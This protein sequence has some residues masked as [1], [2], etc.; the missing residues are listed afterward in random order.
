MD[1]FS[2]QD[3][4]QFPSASFPLTPGITDDNFGLNQ[5]LN[6]GDK[7]PGT[8]GFYTPLS[9][10]FLEPAALTPFDR[11]PSELL[12]PPANLL[13]SNRLAG[14][15]QNPIS[16]FESGFF[17][18]G[19]TGQV[20][21]DFLSDG[22][23]YKGELAFFNLEG[24]ESLGLGSPAFIKEA[25][26]RSLSGN[27]E[28][29]EGDIVI[30][31]ATEG[32]KEDFRFENFNTN[33]GEYLGIK[34][35]QAKPGDKY[36]FMLVPNGK[37]QEVFDALSNNLEL[38]GAKRPLFSM[39]TANPNDAFHVGQI[40]DITG[41][42][43]LF[44][45]EDQRTDTNSDRDYNDVIFRVTGAAGTAA[46][47]SEVIN[48]NL[49]WTKT[50]EG[51]GFLAAVQAPEIE[52]TLA[53]DTGTDNADSLTSD[54]TV[55]GT[56]QTT[57]EIASL[58]AGFNDTPVGDFREVK[59]LLQ[60]DGSF[61][62]DRAKLEEIYGAPLADGAYSLYLQSVDDKGNISS[63]V[64]LSFELDTVSP[65]ITSAIAEDTGVSNTDGIT[66]KLA[67]AG[68]VTG[69]NTFFG[70]SLD[71][72]NF[73]ESA[74]EDD[75]SFALERSQIDI[76]T[77]EVLPDGEGSIYL[78]SSDE[79]GNESAISE[80]SFTLDSALPELTFSEDL[81]NAVFTPGAR[82]AGTANGTG[83]DL[84]FLSYAF[85]E[86]SEISIDVSD[87][88]EFDKELDLSA[89]PAGEHTLSFKAIDR[90]GNE[91][92]VSY[93]VTV[94][95]A[96]DEIAPEIDV[97][98]EDTGVEG[99]GITSRVR[100]EGQITDTSELA[101]IRVGFE[102][103]PEDDVDNPPEDNVDNPPE[104]DVDN[105]PEEGEDNLTDITEEV[106]HD[107]R[108]VLDATKLQEI[109][110]EPLA[111]GEHVL[112]VEATDVHDNTS[113][114]E[115][116]FVLD[117]AEPV[118]N[119]AQSLENATL[120]P[121][122]RISGSAK[123]EEGSGIVEL[124]YRIGD[125][126]EVSVQASETG[127]FDV[128][129]DLSEV[130]N[131]QQTLTVSATDKAGN[132]STQVFPV[133][134]APLLPPTVDHPPEIQVSLVND[135][136]ESD[137]DKIT[138]DPSV[139]GRVTDSGQVAWLR[140]GLEDM[141]EA[142]F[143]DVA[144][145]ADGSWSLDRAQL[146]AIYGDTLPTGDRT[147][148]FQAADTNE[149]VSEIKE[150]T[151]TLEPRPLEIVEISP[152]LT[153]EHVSL[154]REILIRFSAPVNPDTVSSDNLKVIA[155]GAE[156]AGRWVV[157]S[158]G[159]F[160]RF[161]PD[162]TWAESAEIRIEIDGDA[163]TGIDGGILDADAD[164]TPGGD[165]THEFRT[166][167][168]TRIPDT[169]V[170]GYVRDSYSDSPIVG[171]TI[172]VDGLP[173][174]SATTDENGFF[175]LED[176]PGPEFFVHIDG[177]TATNAPEGRSYPIVGKPFH[178]VPGE[179]VQLTMDGTAFD[180]HLPSM[181]EGDVVDLSATESQSVGFGAAGKAALQQMLPNVDAAAWER[182][183][184]E[185]AP[186]SAVDKHG[187]AATK[188][189]I[190]P[191]PPDK[192]PGPLPH[193]I[194]PQ[195]VVSIQALNENGL[196]NN[197]D[198]PAAVTFPNV[199]GLA[200]G[201]Q[202]EIMSFNHDSGRWESVGTGTVTDDGQAI[203][204]DPGVGIL[205]PGWHALVPV[206]IGDSCNPDLYDADRDP[207]RP[208]TYTVVQP[209]PEISGVKDYLFSEDSGS[210]TL[211]FSN[212]AHRINHNLDRC[213][214]EN[215]NATPL[216]VLIDMDAPEETKDFLELPSL[217]QDTRGKAAFE[218]LPEQKTDIKIDIKDLLGDTY[219]EDILYGTRFTIQLGTRNRN[220]I[221][222][223]IDAN[224][225]I[226][227]Y[228]SAYKEE[229]FVYRLLDAADSLHGDGTIEMA[230]TANDSFGGVKR[231]RSLEL[232]VAP[233]AM[234]S[235]EVDDLTHFKYE[236]EEALD[237]ASDPD[238]VPD[239]GIFTFDP[240]A[241]G[242][243]LSSIVRI[244]NPDGDEVGNLTLKGDGELQEWYIDENAFLDALERLSTGALLGASP[245]ELEL[246][247]TADKRQS[248]FDNVV[249][250]VE[251][252]LS[253]FIAGWT[254]TSSPTSTGINID[255]FSTTE[256]RPD[257][258]GNVVEAGSSIV[259]NAFLVDNRVNEVD[260][261]KELVA[262]RASYSV[263]EQNFRLS[264][265]LNEQASGEI[266]IYLDNIFGSPGFHWDSLEPVPEHFQ[267]AMAKIVA[268]E[269]GHNIG[270]E[271]TAGRRSDG[272]VGKVNL[273]NQLIDVM[274]SGYD[275]TYYDRYEF[276]RTADA[277]QVGL[278]TDWTSAQAQDAL[279]Y[280]AAYS[281]ESD[282][283]SEPRL[284]DTIGP[285]PD[286]YVTDVE[287][288]NDGVLYVVADS[289]KAF[290]PNLDF[291]KIP[292]DGSDGEKA[293]E[294]LLL[295][296]VGDRDLNIADFRL[297]GSAGIQFSQPAKTSLAPGETTPLVITFDPTASG[298]QE[299]TLT[300]DNDGSV[301]LYEFQIKGVGQS[302]DGDIRVNADNNNVGGLSVAA[303][304][305]TVAEFATISNSG[306]KAL[307]VS[308][309][310]INDPSGK[311][312]FSVARL[313]NPLVLNPGDTYDLDVTFDAKFV[314]LQ[315]AEISIFSD[316]PDTP[317][318][319]QT[320]VG[321]GLAA[322]GS[323]LQ[324][325]KDYV[326]IDLE[327]G[328]PLRT[329]SLDSGEFEFFLRPNSRYNQAIFDPDSGLISHNFGTT[330]RSG[331][332]TD[333]GTSG[334]EASLA[335][336]SDGDGLPDDVEWAIG[337]SKSAKDTDKDGIDDFVEIQQNLDGLGAGFP[338]GI[339]SSLNLE[340]V[341]EQVVPEGEHI[342]VAT[343]RHGLAIL[344]SN[345]FNNPIQLGQIDLRGYAYDVGVDSN[346]EIAAVATNTGL[347]L[348]D[349]SDPN[350]PQLKQTVP[351]A[352]REVEVANGLAYAANGQSLK[353]VN[354]E[355][356]SVIQN[357]TLPGSGSITGMARE[358]TDL[359]AYVSG[360]RPNN[361]VS[362]IDISSAATGGATV[363]GSVSGLNSTT[364]HRIFAS[365]DTVWVPGGGIHTV[366]VSDPTN[367]KYV[368]RSD[369]ALAARSIALNGPQQN[370]GVLAPDR[371]AFIE[372]YDT[373]DPN[374]TNSDDLLQRFPLSSNPY[375]VAISRGVAYVGTL[376]GVEVL[377]YSP[378]DTEAK[379]PTPVTIASPLTGTELVPGA[380]L[381]VSI[382]AEDDFQLS[383][384]EL[385]ANG[386]AIGQDVSYPF[387]FIT[388]VPEFTPQDTA[389]NLQV[390]AFDTAGNSSLSNTLIWNI[391]DPTDDEP[392]TASI[393]SNVTGNLVEVGER[394]QIDA[395]VRDNVWVS[396]VELL[397]NGKVVD[398]DV[399]A[400]FEFLTVAPEIAPGAETLE[401]QV[402]ATDTGGNTTLSNALSWNLFVPDLEPPTVSINHNAADREPFTPGV[403]VTPGTE[404]PISINASD[405]VEV[406][407]VELLVDG[408]VVDTQESDL[409]DFTV[410]APDAD[411]TVLKIQGRGTDTNG[412]T[413]LSEELSFDINRPSF[414]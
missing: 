54:P 401:V 336:D 256:A 340:G 272:S 317:I 327:S 375:D 304:P 301:P 334:F 348:V 359:Y 26:R 16:P 174:A 195:L 213:E 243:D 81:E 382:D 146:E 214:G 368:R 185:F 105:P 69:E 329:R 83:S 23:S 205:A 91:K 411:G 219:E 298:E 305:L 107:G 145:E 149:N 312:Q 267:K 163:V 309:I 377:N 245:A 137:S 236:D 136:G 55:V 188:A 180:I 129:L 251:G 198:T 318:F 345:E 51:L 407:N 263:A 84:L 233:N 206:T 48:P 226:V 187:N 342:Y 164:G 391:L 239:W 130:A 59:D 302:P 70:L 102:T 246:I 64:E 103:A 351:G 292:A 5:G 65:G 400:P 87:I 34:T 247:D 25:A 114:V 371:R 138:S 384:V 62:F 300:I 39:A 207:P 288:L 79:A 341:S 367:P 88:G 92:V 260:G 276:Y 237:P 1:I 43:T 398:N 42:G 291:G 122:A 89:V 280:F 11:L 7:L 40:A 31:D 100:L 30:R 369:S 147:L 218:L 290:V 399:S 175:I 321:T 109:A 165:I 365:D 397:V 402:R 274:R 212:R 307:T 133:Q 352:A 35:F 166:T 194:T 366:D 335:P 203:A 231:E 20:T 144:I 9:G 116:P 152:V 171:A 378:F 211:S 200:P 45:M 228:S 241:T 273:P 177:S 101:K 376:N 111:D 189:A 162:N 404:I 98:L 13:P 53:S 254:R 326:A 281:V 201:E 244:K 323:A 73:F 199:E 381:A 60:D 230:D 142:D 331:Q 282:G 390:R 173:E 41:D 410:K 215:A 159:E 232:K 10:D 295:M 78:K 71:G 268:H 250:N 238:Y 313:A 86:A 296:N 57:G 322:E 266:D 234:P 393:S 306:D 223:P 186:N 176:M 227:T 364:V 347:E 303:A 157:N 357:L 132:V 409:L 140:V 44:V 134:V 67:I 22:G 386:R 320:V 249:A 285:L 269:L 66:S 50:P 216:M 153:E 110:G 333:L 343:G 106:W 387:D 33:Q 181:A 265:A 271:H 74:L 361:T 358:G 93:P 413:A 184:V 311:D 412:N 63:F 118:V 96:L 204:S 119:L 8:G 90:A 394:I 190:I 252:L 299:A 191:V 222:Q 131:G 314:G 143:V 388:T 82:L 264:E 319:S 2:H 346:L 121:G 193:G 115:I 356:G 209:I 253:S 284:F 18:A 208:S 154:D 21:F 167:S 278:G 389:F 15:P 403:Q 172:R 6:P 17:V 373:S 406:D 355:N 316:D 383:R 28:N 112:R 287:P 396:N 24:M 262:Q 104:D 338:N 36:G 155:L 3:S 297:S 315:R 127:E 19:N 160:A 210:L 4:S 370:L 293:T 344:D 308:E 286:V 80:V 350:E 270:L 14:L 259:G 141:A 150:F 362:V 178:S 49:D 46:K 29:P 353:V 248:I 58:R 283:W 52:V 337:T 12:N 221:W 405:N 156:V 113:T 117:T 240:T 328:P 94:E 392:P 374:N 99:D 294:N 363:V 77:G 279:D 120:Q 148:R 37:V 332:A 310:S 125:S 68:N 202:A 414:F 108:L 182:M 158:S 324:Y 32:A 151:F 379:P 38:Q 72:E 47:V 135:T 75:G 242:Q 76:I 197:F 408:N 255:V 235:L 360:R 339:I 56:V 27:S 372:V 330:S 354:L 225:N 169:D 257:K 139:S 385:L 126:P 380:S 275:S 289:D 170:W 196:V 161:F 85:D 349:I 224:G 220:G 123:D 168:M 277:L 97:Q 183:S 258:D 179:S 217:L 229:V 261:I 61:S 124:S 192:I 95:A 395:D 128:E 325:G